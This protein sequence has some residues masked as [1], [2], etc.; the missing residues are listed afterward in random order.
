MRDPLDNRIDAYE[1]LKLTEESTR[2][3]VQRSYTSALIRRSSPHK[4]LMAAREVL[5]Q[6]TKRALYDLFRYP[7]GFKQT[8]FETPEAVA[9]RSSKSETLEMP[10]VAI[11]LEAESLIGQIGIKWSDTEEME[12]KPVD[13]LTET[14]LPMTPFQLDV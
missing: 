1:T 8:D 14:L 11:Q 10:P 6:T 12:L 4:D 9:I 3:E 2:I 5:A 7:F 13:E